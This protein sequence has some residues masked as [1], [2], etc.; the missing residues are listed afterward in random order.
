MCADII[1]PVRHEEVRKTRTE[2]LVADGVE[3]TVA[4]HFVAFIL[5]SGVDVQTVPVAAA[6]PIPQELPKSHP[7]ALPQGLTMAW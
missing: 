4:A 5:D 1:Q 3:P 2:W 7:Q 6:M